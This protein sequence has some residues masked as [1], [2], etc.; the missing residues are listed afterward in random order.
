MQRIGEQ[1]NVTIPED[2]KEKI[3]QVAKRHDYSR[4]EA[5]RKLLELGVEIYTEFE[6]IG[7]PQLIEMINKGKKAIRDLKQ[8]RIA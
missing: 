7:V 5:T 4:S 1:I 8:R 6:S 3:D 2:L